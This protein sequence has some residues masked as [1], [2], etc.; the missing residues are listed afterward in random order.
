MSGELWWR[1]GLSNKFSVSTT[2]EINNI[3]HVDHVI[4]VSKNA[5]AAELY[6]YSYYDE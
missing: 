3:F 5:A 6:S 4:K 1:L 2:T